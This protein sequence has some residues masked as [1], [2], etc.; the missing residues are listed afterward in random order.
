MD[1]STI[2]QDQGGGV[3]IDDFYIDSIGTT[4]HNP[5][6]ST[7]QTFKYLDL[8]PGRV[9]IKLKLDTRSKV[10]ILPVWLFMGI[11][12]LSSLKQPLKHIL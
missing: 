2:Q 6:K 9:P 7:D 4:A 8:S 12:P 3:D 11:D 5:C 10:N 1:E